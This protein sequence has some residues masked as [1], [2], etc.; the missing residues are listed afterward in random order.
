MNPSSGPAI[1]QYWIDVEKPL[2]A[3]G[4]DQPG[5]ACYQDRSRHHGHTWGG[6]GVIE[7]RRVGQVHSG[8][9]QF[10]RGESNQSI[11]REISDGAVA[12]P[13]KCQTTLS[14]TA[15]VANDV[16][17]IPI[18]VALQKHE[19]NSDKMQNPYPNLSIL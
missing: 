17:A 19:T 6:M 2:A 7:T 13:T 11:L 1:D 8:Q 18:R 12:I 5:G 14:G 3:Q 15:G 16:S 9:V 10:G 4:T